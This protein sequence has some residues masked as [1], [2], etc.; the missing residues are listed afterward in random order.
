MAS[1]NYENKKGSGKKLKVRFV[2]LD[3]N[4]DDDDDYP[5]LDQKDISSSNLT[6]STLDSDDD[7]DHGGS[8]I[9]FPPMQMMSTFGYDPN[10]IPSCIFSS[11]SRMD[12]SVQSN[13]SLFSIHLGNTNF[14]KDH[15]LALN[16]SGELHWTNDLIIMSPPPMALERVEE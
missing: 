7:D 3:N 14:S 15:V 11:P 10:R 6:D 13:E 2:I 5:I 9:Q 16:K 12:W 1:L 4:D 8:I